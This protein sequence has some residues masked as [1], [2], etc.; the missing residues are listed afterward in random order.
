[1]NDLPLV[2][3]RYADSFVQ[4]L[5]RLSAQA[6]HVLERVHLSEEIL[7]VPDGLMPVDQLWRLTALA[8]TSTGVWHI[9]LEAGLTPLEQHSAFGHHL[10]LAP[11]LY[12]AMTTFCAEARAELSHA[13]FHIR[14][15]PEMVWFCGGR[16]DGS[17]EEIRQVELYR[18]GMMIQLVRWAVGSH[19][20]PREVRLQSCNVH[21]LRDT[22]LVRDV[23][24]HSGYP[25]LAIG[26][27]PGLFSL[28]H[29]S[30]N[31]DNH[32]QG[33]VAAPLAPIPEGRLPVALKE[34]IRTHI[35]AGI[36]ALS[37]IARTLDMPERTLQRRLADHGVSYSQLK[38][39]TRF[40]MT[41]EMLKETNVS[42]NDI[43]REVGY[44][45]PTHFFRAFKR[46][47]G[48]TPLQYR[49]FLHP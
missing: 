41:R 49:K 25:M 7:A 9:G 17:Q 16:I 23:N 3:V 13:T 15:E 19:W 36:G 42:F 4:V 24:V 29:K 44:A 33:S 22:P 1:M 14:H 11:T 12:Q 21:D 2:R 18:Y 34:V 30:G 26:L 27:S 31:R 20:Q 35:H 43:A 10:F 39:Q 5:K 8:A 28:P 40:D 37:E 38:E 46:I 32:S 48:I 45:N 47:A 6:D